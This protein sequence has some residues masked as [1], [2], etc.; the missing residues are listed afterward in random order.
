MKL[1][2]HPVLF[3]LIPVIVASALALGIWSGFREFGVPQ[4]S[5]ESTPVSATVIQ[6]PRALKPF[7]LSDHTGKPFSRD[8]LRENWTF[9]AFGYTYCPDI[10]PTTLAVLSQTADLLNQD[11]Q[12][13]RPQFIFVSVDPDRDSLD[14]L[15]TYVPYFNPEFIGATGPEADLQ[16]LTGQLG[17]LYRKV[18][19]EETA[20]DYLVD[21]SAS[22]VLTDPQGRLQAVFSAP[23][24]ART[25]ASDFRNIER[26]YHP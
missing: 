18:K 7:T 8:S 26:R 21:H 9:I 15:A 25:M 22:I 19:D 20:L 5:W 14:R 4:D 13:S 1:S 16:Q 10:C 24:D 11:A 23:H 12:G 17:I 6:N 3:W 2:A